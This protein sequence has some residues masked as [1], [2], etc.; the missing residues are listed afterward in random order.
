MGS[1][2]CI[3][4]RDADGCPANG[5]FTIS[6]PDEISI[7]LSVSNES[8]EGAMDGAID[9]IVTGGIGTYSFA[10]SGPQSFAENTQNIDLLGPAEY[11]L[12]VTDENNC[13]LLACAT[14]GA[15]ENPCLGFTNESIVL[16]LENNISC[17]G[18]L[19]GSATAIIEDGA[20][21]FT[22]LWSNDETGQTAINLPV[23]ESTV[24]VTD[25]NGCESEQTILSLIHI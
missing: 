24:T 16:V 10:W 11:C 12:L 25:A 13:T 21:P 18:E 7:E 14:I 20:Q 5:A 4:D 6:E 2:M 15:G 23:G 1:E 22:F 9:A 19:D 3:R 8:V 17:F